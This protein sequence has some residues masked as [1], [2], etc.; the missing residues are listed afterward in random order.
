MPDKKRQIVQQDIDA[1]IPYAS[2]AR[3]HNDAQV[4]Q[5]AA[6]IKEFGWTNPVLI[7]EDGGIIAGHGRV[8]AARKLGQTKVPCIILSGLSDAQRRAYVIADNKLALNAGW[9]YDVLIPELERLGSEDVDLDLLGFTPDELED[10]IGGRSLDDIVD[11]AAD[12]NENDSPETVAGVV[13]IGPYAITVGAERMYKWIELVREASG[14]GKKETEGL[15]LEW[16]RI[17]D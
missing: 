2:N 6:S 1:L 9:D 4:A 14:G 11:G 10:L 13:R 7:D 12:I 5:I 3:T 15:I 8:M 16:L 17:P